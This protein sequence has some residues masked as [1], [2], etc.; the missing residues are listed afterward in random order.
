MSKWSVYIIRCANNALYTGITT[1]IERRLKEHRGKNG[2][3]AKALKGKGP[4]QMV[5][6]TSV[7]NR[8]VASKLE[9][10][11]KQL[12]KPSKEQLINS[13]APLK[14]LEGKINIST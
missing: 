14:Y 12:N 11:I 1:D 13:P 5:W 9:Y 8:S 4:L 6:H 3:G 10:Q 7:E 2:K